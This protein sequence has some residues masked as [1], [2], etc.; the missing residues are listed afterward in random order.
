MNRACFAKEKHQNSQKWVKFMNFSFWAFFWFGLPGRLLTSCAT[1]GLC[2]G[3]PS[4][5]PLRRAHRDHVGDFH[6]Q[7]D[8]PAAAYV[9]EHGQNQDMHDDTGLTSKHF[10]AVP[11]DTQLLRT[12]KDSDIQSVR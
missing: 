7:L 2:G 9:K 11:S 3:A 12:K 8:L 4:A 5:K 10:R 6:G 1:H